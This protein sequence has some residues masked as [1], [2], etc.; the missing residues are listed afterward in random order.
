MACL[1]CVDKFPLEL[2]RVSTTTFPLELARGPPQL[3]LVRCLWLAHS[4]AFEGCRVRRNGRE[5]GGWDA[6]RLIVVCGWEVSPST[7]HAAHFINASS[8]S[9]AGDVPDMPLPSNATYYKSRPR[10]FNLVARIKLSACRS[11][12]VLTDAFQQKKL[13]GPAA[14]A[15]SLLKSSIT[16]PCRA[17]AASWQRGMGVWEGTPPAPSTPPPA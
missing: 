17:T 4:D 6:F 10:P 1:C 8:S 3:F 15:A 9:E 12:Q 16:W 14:R 11:P 13:E 2:A 7:R 5:V